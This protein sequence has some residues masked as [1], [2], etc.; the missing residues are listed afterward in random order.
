VALRQRPRRPG[1]GRSSRGAPPG[2]TRRAFWPVASGQPENVDGRGA[3]PILLLD[4]ATPHAGSLETR[5]WFPASS[6]IA[7]VGGTNH[8]NSLFGGV[9]CVDDA[10]A[11]YLA[12][13]AAADAAARER[14]RRR[15]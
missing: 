14:R 7:T 5:R 8:A 2:S 12:V 3:P 13:G 4:A 11:A 9:A 15:V 10:V 1:R 6:Q